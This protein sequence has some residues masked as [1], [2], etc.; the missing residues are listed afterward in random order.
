METSVIECD[1]G[2]TLTD[3]QNEANIGSA[4]GSNYPV[5]GNTYSCSS[6]NSWI[7]DQTTR[8]NAICIRGEYEQ[9]RYTSWV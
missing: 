6:T 8:S 5:S 9:I 7:V 4:K 1:S 2:D 3:C